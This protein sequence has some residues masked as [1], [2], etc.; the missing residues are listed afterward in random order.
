VDPQDDARRAEHPDPQ[1]ERHDAVSRSVDAVSRGVDGFL[2]S[3][4][5]GTD[6]SRPFP[7]RDPLA[8]RSGWAVVAPLLVVL[9][10]GA[11]YLGW[12]ALS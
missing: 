7:D 12:R 1:A 8:P 4:A 5:G 3:A 2:T 10:G 6:L 9:A 11:A